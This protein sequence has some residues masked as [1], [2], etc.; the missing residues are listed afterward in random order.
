MRDPP[1]FVPANVDRAEV[2]FQRLSWDQVAPG[3]PDRVLGVNFLSPLPA[4]VPNHS[5]KAVFS[6]NVGPQGV[7][8]YSVPTWYL[9][10][11]APS[12]G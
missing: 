11:G 2:F 12:L 3:T 8:H 6:F 4:D 7:G 9:V 10:H 5:G 1:A